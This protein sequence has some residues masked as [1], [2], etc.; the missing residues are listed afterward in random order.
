ML[1]DRSTGSPGSSRDLAHAE[2]RPPTDPLTGYGPWLGDSPGARRL[3]AGIETA[4]REGPGTVLVHGERGVGQSDVA[5]LLHARG[6]RG[7]RSLTS[8][9]LGTPAAIEALLGLRRSVD[10]G[11]GPGN[12]LVTDLQRGSAEE[13]ESLLGLLS[14]QGAALRTG[15]LLCTTAE[16]AVLRGKALPFDRLLGRAGGAS[17]HVPRLRDRADDVPILTRAALE[18]VAARWD[19]PVRGVSPQALA[20]LASH[21]F[22]G[23]LRELEAMLEVAVLRTHG[24]WLTLESFPGLAGAAPDASAAELVVRLPGSSLREVELQTLRLALRLTGGR[25]V[26]TA[27]LLGI[28]RHA[29]RRKLEKHGLTPQ[30]EADDDVALDE[31]E[32]SYI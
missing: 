26:R 13:I 27:E 12:V 8:L 9:R 14:A 18:I 23:N 11:D 17:L 2:F 24:D 32:D 5:Q 16:P 7:S 28:T 22:P 20:R 30:R 25:V 19:R 15:L 4:L 31:D 3:R 10:A 21:D 1:P 6:R 29:L